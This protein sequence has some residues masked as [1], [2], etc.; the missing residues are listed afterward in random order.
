MKARFQQ[1]KEKEVK[2]AK[3]DVKVK[4]LEDEKLLLIE[5]NK[6]EIKSK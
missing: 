4:D 3:L 6:E 5:Q 2:L 1:I